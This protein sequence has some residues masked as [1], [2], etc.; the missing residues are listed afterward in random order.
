MTLLLNDDHII[1][2]KLANKKE[3]EK[4]KKIGLKI[5]KLLIKYFK[6]INFVLVDYKMEFGF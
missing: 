3:I 4:I 1:L 6:K 5:N 2:L